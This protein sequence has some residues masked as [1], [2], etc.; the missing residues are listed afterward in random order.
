M[1]NK[2]QNALYSS[3]KF[4]W[5]FVA[6]FFLDHSNSHHI[7]NMSFFNSEINLICSKSNEEFHQMFPF[8]RD[9]VDATG[10]ARLHA[11]HRFHT[12]NMHA[13]RRILIRIILQLMA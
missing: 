5:H 6:F 12:V 9:V 4:Q 7:S 13:N 1:V 10:S 8:I 2:K 11:K 3:M